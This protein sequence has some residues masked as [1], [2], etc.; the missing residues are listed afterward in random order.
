MSR[1]LTTDEFI[2]KAV[3]IHNNFYDYS[4]TIYIKSKEKVTIICP[5]HGEFMQKPN[6][7]LLGRGCK[8]CKGDKTSNRCRLTK[9]DF[10][11]KSKQVHGDKYDYSLV[12]YM[13]LSKFVTIICPLHGTFKIR[14]TNH[15]HGKQG[16]RKCSNIHISNVSSWNKNEW[17][18]KKESIHFSGYKLYIIKCSL[19]EEVFYKIGR[20][21]NDL[22]KRFKSTKMPYNYEIIYVVIGECD[23]IFNLEV[24][25]KQKNKIY[26]YKP[27]ICF[28]GKHECFSKVEY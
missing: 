13:G 26:K 18:D 2:I 23:D 20:T 8:K 14:G 24:E 10:I 6:C 27:K 12:D 28:S 19:D 7:H 17:C 16:C 9:E 3:K 5:T 11:Y 4:N 1:T 21:C 25:L 22:T 15:I